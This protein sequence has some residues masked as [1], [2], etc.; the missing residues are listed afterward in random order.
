MVAKI[1][2][3]GATKGL[4]YFPV[5]IEAQTIETVLQGY[6]DGLDSTLSVTSPVTA[7]HLGIDF[8]N[9]VQ[10]CHV[11]RYNIHHTGDPG[12]RS[13]T[14]AEVGTLN[15][16]QFS[17]TK[18]GYIT[19]DD[20]DWKELP[21]NS[22]GLFFNGVTVAANVSMSRVSLHGTGPN[23]VANV[24]VTA[25][26][27]TYTN[28]DSVTEA[29]SIIGGTI[30]AVELLSGNETVALNASAASLI[31]QA[32]EKVKV[33]YSVAPTIKKQRLNRYGAGRIRRGLRRRDDSK[34]V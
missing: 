15:L 18:G 1:N 26:P 3:T 4:Q 32:G 23:E 17:G 24:S 12:A 8:S 2:Q 5:V 31:L 13:A 11:S 16:G 19:F 29:I 34:H 27:F 22:T 10:D 21:E 14:F 20:C 9:G 7:T 33:T 6:I 30:S 25:S 28:L